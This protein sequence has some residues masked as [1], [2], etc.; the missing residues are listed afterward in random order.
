M[1]RCSA[2]AVAGRGGPRPARDRQAGRTQPAQ[3]RPSG[4][5]PRQPGI[6]PARTRCPTLTGVGRSTSGGPGRRGGAARSPS[7]SGDVVQDGESG[8][9]MRPWHVSSRT[10]M[11]THRCMDE[12]RCHSGRHGPTGDR[13][14]WHHAA[15]LAQGV[16]G[17]RASPEA[18][19][20]AAVR[21]TVPPWTPQPRRPAIGGSGTTGGASSSTPQTCQCSP[22]STR[23]LEDG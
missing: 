11:R 9:V 18:G 15:V 6:E 8:R 20:R 13:G 17:R 4:P 10:S 3:A 19:V 12:C 21:H 22:R 14:D 5:E 2:A 7:R 16:S 1:T 23:T